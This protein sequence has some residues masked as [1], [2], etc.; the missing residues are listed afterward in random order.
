M[1]E[2]LAEFEPEEPSKYLHKLLPEALLDS[3]SKAK[4]RSFVYLYFTSHNELKKKVDSLSDRLSDSRSSVDKLSSE[5]KRLTEQGKEKDNTISQ[6][7]EQGKEKDNTITNLQAEIKE[8]NNLLEYELNKCQKQL[9][10]LK[11]GLISKLHRDMQMEL[12]GITLIANRLKPED[13]VSLSMYIT[14]I[15]QLLT[16]LKKES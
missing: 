12:D 11:T 3:N 1:A 15:T 8:T 14:N 2:H 16:I 4:I 7:T 6:L 9:Q 13:S 10:G 5:V